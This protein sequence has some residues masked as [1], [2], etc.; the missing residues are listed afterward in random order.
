M[1]TATRM[2][3]AGVVPNP[4]A[5]WRAFRPLLRA[6]AAA[7]ALSSGSAMAGF[8]ESDSALI[9]DNFSGG[10]L[11][12]CEFTSPNSVSFTITP[13]DAPPINPSAWYSFRVS[14]KE[15]ES[16]QLIL[17]FVDGHARY[18][19]KI[20]SDGETWRRLDESQVDISE[21]R[22]TMTI[23]LARSRDPIF[24]SAQ[25]LLVNDDYE[26]W[27]HSLAEHPEVMSRTLGRSIQ[28]RPIQALT[29]APKAEVV[30]LF[31]RQHPPEITGGLA[32]QS[33]VDEVFSDSDLANEFRARFMLVL[34]PLINPDGV[35]AGHW[36]HNMGGRD[37]NRD[38]GPFTQPEIQSVK[39][40]IDELDN[41]GLAPKLMLDFHSTQR[42]RFYTQMPEDFDEEL[43]FARDWL[44]RARLRMPDFD[45]LYDPRKPS[46]QENT[47]NYFY[48]TY[49]I[50]AITYEIGDEVDRGELRRTS[51]IF[52]QE[53]MRVMLERD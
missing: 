23:A 5:S 8:C 18:W 45:F 1:S 40:L 14:P 16:L 26:R 41:A 44:D 22:S 36:R 4:R 19:P 50:P 34:V 24:V 2:S 28:G 42:S 33:F 51:P 7:V 6:A 15:E 52:A 25:E 9:D 35:A 49:H 53:M 29:T 3:H 27:M 20:S 30:Y 11:G 32:M 46:G 31:G 48:A 13:E 39:R 17:T 21:D 43:D 12:V 37:L 10:N 38:W 47:K